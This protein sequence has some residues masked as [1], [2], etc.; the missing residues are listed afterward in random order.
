MRNDLVSFLFLRLQCIL[1]R[2]L[3]LSAYTTKSLASLHSPSLLFFL[4]PSHTQFY[5]S[6]VPKIAF[7][8]HLNTHS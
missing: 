2:V 3:F 6:L 4:C 1:P 5:C 8:N 7:P